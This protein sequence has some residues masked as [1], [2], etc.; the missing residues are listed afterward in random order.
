[1]QAFLQ[2]FHKA[3]QSSYSA[4]SANVYFCKKGTPQPT[5]YQE[6]SCTS[7]MRTAGSCSFQVCNLLK[8][9]YITKFTLDISQNFQNKFKTFAQGFAFGNLANCSFLETSRRISSRNTQKQVIEFQTELQNVEISPMTLLKRDSS[10]DALLE[11][12]KNRKTHRKLLQWSQFSV[13]L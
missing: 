8:K 5:L 3:V 6:F 4:D 10:T 1:M 12:L 9:N 13:K 11:I 7:K 2:A